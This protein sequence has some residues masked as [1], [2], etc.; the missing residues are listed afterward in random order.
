M[1]MKP[2][3][4]LAVYFSATGTTQ[5]VVEHIAQA[6]ANALSLPWEVR[7]FTLPAAR[8]APLVFQG[9]DLVV[10]G[11]PV[12]A[13]RVPNVLLNYL[14]ALEGHGALAVP[15]VLFGNRDFDDALIELRDLLEQL[16]NVPGGYSARSDTEAKTVYVRGA[17]EELTLIDSS[18]LRIVA[19]LK[20]V[21]GSGT[22]TIPVR[23][24]LDA[25]G[26][27]GVIGDYSIVVSVTR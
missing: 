5:K 21:T 22:Y 11:T 20:D 3:R 6:L 17:A 13:G 23:V 8:T 2:H 4:I 12:I 25:A 10:F 15:V 14:T 1:G 24:Y 26:S 16:Q 19:D 9:E 7:D 27:V 18:Q